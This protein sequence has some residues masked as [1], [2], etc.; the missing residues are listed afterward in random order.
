MGDKD[1]KKY[2]AAHPEGA[3]IGGVV[4][5]HFDDLSDRTVLMSGDTKVAMFPWPW[6]VYQETELNPLQEK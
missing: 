6:S 2:A 5:T 3:V 1:L 4:G